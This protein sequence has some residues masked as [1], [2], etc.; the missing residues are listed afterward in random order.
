MKK[1]LIS[2]HAKSHD[3]FLMLENILNISSSYSLNGTFETSLKSNLQGKDV[4]ALLCDYRLIENNDCYCNFLDTIKK[5]PLVKI[6]IITDKISFESITVSVKSGFSGILSFNNLER[7]L[8]PSL[9]MILFKNQ[10]YID[11]MFHKIIMNKLISFNNKP[12]GLSDSNMTLSR[13]ET[14]IMNILHENSISEI[15]EKLFISEKT[16]HS[17]CRNIMIK[18]NIKSLRKLRLIS[19]KNSLLG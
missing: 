14:D 19:F 10:N 4:K 12:T 7:N 3:D 6:I 5:N 2:S 18:M 11:P 8:V 17:H 9:D 1:I 16:V 13:R 15:S